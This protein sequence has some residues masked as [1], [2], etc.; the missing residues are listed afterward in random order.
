MI[1][2]VH[3]N[4]CEKLAETLAEALPPPGDT[5]ALFDGPWLVVPTRPLTLWLN[6]ELARHRGIAGHT[7]TMTFDG[8]IAR[9]TSEALPDVILV[10]RGHLVGE[11]L[12]LLGDEAFLRAPAVAPLAAYLRAAGDEA[13][14]IDRR[15]VD[16]AL[17]LG[18]LFD[19]WS[20]RRPDV[21][22]RWR[23]APTELEPDA[24][25]LERAER[26]LYAGLFGPDGR[27][28]QR[29]AAE[30]RRFLTRDAF[31]AAGLDRHWRPPSAVHVF[32][33]LDISPGLQ[34]TL[35]RLGQRTEVRV[36]AVNPCR[37]F[38]EDLEAGSF[39]PPSPP[40]HDAAASAPA[41]RAKGRGRQTAA[42]PR[43][44]DLL[45]PAPA[46]PNAAAARASAPTLTGNR[47]NP[48]LAAWA[49][50]GRD[51]HRRL[52]ELTDN[53]SEF[54]AAE[55]GTNSVLARV[56]QDI[57]DRRPRR[58]GAE[59]LDLDADGSIA[60]IGAANPRREME[61]VAARIWSLVRA[62]EEAARVAAD[63]GRPHVPLQ[64]SDVAVMVAGP[65][66]PHMSLV[67]EVFH[68]ADDLP[69]A[70]IDRGFGA[71]SGVAEAVLGL[72]ALPLGALARREVLD[73]ISHTN[74]RARFPDADP[75]A[76]LRLCEGLTIA[77]G[78][79]RA[80]LSDTYIDRDTFNWDQGCRRLVLGRFARGPRSGVEEPM[81]LAAPLAEAGAVPTGDGYIPAEVD[82]ALR[83]DADALATLMRSL[84]ADVRFARAAQL[85]VPQWAHFVRALMSAYVAPVRPEDESARLA[86]FAAL[87]QLA[88][89]AATDVRVP[90]GVAVEL[91]RAVLSDLRGARGQM[92]G[93]GV[94]VGS[95]GTL[96]GLP[97][98]IVFIVGLEP[99]RFPSS[100]AASPLDVLAGSDGAAEPSPRDAD[101]YLFLEAVLAA[102]D[103]LVLTGLDRDPLTGEAREPSPVVL[104][105]LDELGRGYVRDTAA[106]MRS[107]PLHRDEDAEARD[108]FPMAATEAHARLVGEAA[109]AANIPGADDPAALVRGLSPTTRAVLSPLLGLI[110]PPS[111]G[112]TAA[113]APGRA[114]TILSLAD[115]RRF[116]ECPLQ[117][118]ARVFL[119]LR[120]LPDD[121][122]ARETT[123]E[124]F[125]LPRALERGLLN[126]VLVAAWAAPAAP[127]LATLSGRYD[128]A[129]ARYRAAHRLPAALFRD[130]VRSRHLRFLR[131]WLE[132][133]TTA[134]PTFVGP[135][136][137][138]CFGRPEPYAAPAVTRE[139]IRLHVEV[140]DRGPVEVELH[141]P[142][143]PLVGIAAEEAQASLVFA[144]S[145][146]EENDDRD[147]FRALIDLMAIA[148]SAAEGAP[149]PERLAFVFRPSR[150][151]HER[152]PRSVAMRFANLTRVTARSYLGGLATALLGGVH[153]YL[154]PSDAVL[155]A[156]RRDQPLV[157]GIEQTRLDP[158]YRARSVSN[159]GPVPT[160]F[161][162][163]APSEADAVR[164]R[165]ERFGLLLAAL[166]AA[167]PKEKTR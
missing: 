85:T 74:V 125:D 31:L 148:A 47:E 22:D 46:V 71:A 123:D 136:R 57:L 133:A 81:H 83:A 104:E 50:A 149:P 93:A 151:A 102:R 25:P 35:A 107:V 60:V 122:E 159:F 69:H 105:L 79:D 14:A 64:F 77:H 127:D 147:S 167:A 40:A 15:R 140:P 75:A 163:P 80:A 109:R 43:Q 11:L 110:S 33:P 145:T 36:Y 154:F 86:V 24:A 3:S 67:P 146:S 128:E 45:A 27:F 9:L 8:L 144:T 30:A 117:G 34:L 113:G 18:R 156:T 153:G 121:S 152:L 76:W 97:F 26:A 39:A 6:L 52:N 100:R 143:E 66:E 62:D 10:E 139:P 55:P 98:R 112:A 53:D 92:L 89:Q 103:R 164:F 161:D 119:G 99:S 108:A 116:L 91:V 94:V 96:R 17:A 138:I 16:L 88:A 101:R 68:E 2:V 4:R 21:L 1:R 129:A 12:A 142:T 82:P 120:D 130:I 44:L 19:D 32:A 7:D 95:I 141:G 132:H 54:R 137:R 51:A 134:G 41:A 48:W 84:L 158:H 73:V 115:L 29:G 13:S 150:L 166:D 59:R 5:A 162:Y 135:A 49:R 124:P 118:S 37:E 61:S 72:L 65:A 23:A 131:Q 157:E 160:P 87:D 114:R 56:Q 42:N 90:L 155:R 106:L 126:E 20:L 28:A 63:A 111:V 38:W 165:N 78:A 70:V 58:A